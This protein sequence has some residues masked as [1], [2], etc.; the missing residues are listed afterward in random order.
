LQKPVWIVTVAYISDALKGIK[1]KLIQGIWFFKN[2]YY[3]LLNMASSMHKYHVFMYLSVFPPNHSI[4]HFHAFP[5]TSPPYSII[6]FPSYVFVVFYIHTHTHRQTDRQTTLYI[7]IKSMTHKWEKTQD[8]CFSETNLI[9]LIWF[10]PP[11][12][13]YLEDAKSTHHQTAYF[14]KIT[15]YY[16]NKNPQRKNKLENKISQ[17]YLLEVNN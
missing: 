1:V 13:I 10:I 8:T 9:N 12:G 15:F 6:H 7:C 4:L 3:T 11:W 2:D 5:L 17:F 16:I 14:L